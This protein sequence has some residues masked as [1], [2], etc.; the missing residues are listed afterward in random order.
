MPGILVSYKNLMNTF[1]K[2][3]ILQQQV[4]ILQYIR[5]SSEIIATQIVPDIQNSENYTM[6]IFSILW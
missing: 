4:F 5:K 1:L 6:Q 2:V 3:K